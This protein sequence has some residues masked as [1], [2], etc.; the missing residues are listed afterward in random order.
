MELSVQLLRRIYCWNGTRGQPFPWF[1]Y[2]LVGLYPV[3]WIIPSCTF[4]VT[5][6]DNV[7]KLL[8]AVNEQ[9]VFFAIFYKMY[10]FAKKFQQWEQLYYDIQ[11]AFLSVV[12]NT[13][14]QIQKILGH[15]GKSARFLTKYYVSVML[16]DC[17]LYGLAP[18]VF[19]VI[20]YAVTGSYNVP[21]AT[22]LEANYFI[23]GYQTN[24]WIWL[25]FD[26]LLNVILLM[27]GVMLFSIECFI[28]NML[29]GTAC[30]FRILQIEADQLVGNE[31][32]GQSSTDIRNFI[33]LHNSVLRSAGKMEEILRGEI[34]FLF[35][36]TI[37]ALCL[38]MS[39]MSVAFKDVY[40]LITMACVFGYCLFQTFA[41]SNLGSELIEESTAVADAIY[42]SKWYTQDAKSQ[43]NFGFMVMR[44]QK[45]VQLT[46]AKLFVV[47]RYSFTQMIRQ[48]YAVFTMMSRFLDAN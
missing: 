27:H 38:M 21:L 35:M 19:V 18:M 43:R 44:A 16:F 40:L 26:C 41:F 28:W 4:I 12:Q 13:D 45:P 33:V 3:V 31:R 6:R 5:S 30:L 37:F 9:I 46:A 22:P 11:C 8:K 42:R 25:P 7:T 10:S 15:V 29:H 17:A 20:K 2:L 32:K 14:V 24:F 48:T 34:L 39:V 23:P 36:S 47:T 1:G